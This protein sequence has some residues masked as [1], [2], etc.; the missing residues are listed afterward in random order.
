MTHP[1]FLLNLLLNAMIKS[2]EEGRLLTHARLCQED[3]IKICK[4]FQPESQ[5][6]KCRH[7]S[8][9]EASRLPLSIEVQLP[10]ASIADDYEEFE[11]SKLITPVVKYSTTYLN[12]QQIWASY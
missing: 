1:V 8:Q 9:T 5:L 12:T 2:D 3:K 11:H 6:P 7:L 10:Q 4:K